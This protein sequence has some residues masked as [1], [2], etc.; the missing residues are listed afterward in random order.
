MLTPKE[1]E[2]VEELCDSLSDVQRKRALENLLFEHRQYT[3]CGTP[4]ECAQRKEW[5][6]M[7]YEDIMANFNSIVGILRKEVADIK[8]EA[9]VEKKSKK[10]G[11]PRK[12]KETTDIDESTFY[13]C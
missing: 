7:S 9:V 1:L 2:I 13:V 3:R 11:R 6:Q 10:R 4:E 5:M 12:I 8:T